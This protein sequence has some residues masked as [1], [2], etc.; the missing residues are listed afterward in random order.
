MFIK[1]G[2]SLSDECVNSVV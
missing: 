1:L 2:F